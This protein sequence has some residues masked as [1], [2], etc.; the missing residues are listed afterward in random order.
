MIKSV[1]KVKKFTF[2]RR[3]FDDLLMLAGSGL[4]VYA[5]SILSII[6]A[7]YVSG[8]LLIIFGV[9]VGLG[10]EDSK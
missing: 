5:T 4:I 6:A 9:L 3:H 10:M 1:R 2:F 7:L 8:V